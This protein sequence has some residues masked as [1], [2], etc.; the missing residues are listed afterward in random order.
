MVINWLNQYLDGW[1]LFSHFYF[2]GWNWKEHCI[3]ISRTTLTSHLESGKTQIC[4]SKIIDNFKKLWHKFIQN[5]RRNTMNYLLI[6]STVQNSKSFLITYS[7]FYKRVLKSPIWNGSEI[8]R[9]PNFAA[10]YMS[11]I[12]NFNLCSW[13][14]KYSFRFY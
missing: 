2:I 4:H 12:F 7:R 14:V 3:E 10:W 9:N 1:K 5:S 8:F 6:P 11:T 13:K